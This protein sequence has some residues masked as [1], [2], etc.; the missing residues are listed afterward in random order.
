MVIP[1]RDESST[2]GDTVKAARGLPGVSR[3]IV[4]D[5][6]SR[7]DTAKEADLAGAEVVSSRKK[8]GKG[9][10]LGLG[11]RDLSEDVVVFLD[12]DLGREVRKAS[13]LLDPV[14]MG[15]ADMCVAGVLT[16]GRGGLGIVRSVAY[17]GIKRLTGAGFACPLS[18]QR[19][20]TRELIE[21]LDSLA[22]GFGVEVG[23]TVDVLS[24]GY[25]L[26]EVPS[27]MVHRGTGRGIA[28]F[29]HRGRQLWDILK[30]LLD[31]GLLSGGR[32]K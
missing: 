4:V 11:I 17:W 12:G 2:I 14:R 18:G 25:R 9:G 30:A 10:A 3:V 8:L 6:G 31:R 7:D 29:L 26:L 24:K 20:L 13:V 28:G 23:L 22:A 15:N 32:L 27:G 5:D 1:A 21:N 16:E 19:A